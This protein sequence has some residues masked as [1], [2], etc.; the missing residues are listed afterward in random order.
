MAGTFS[1][2]CDGL[3][4][5]HVVGRTVRPTIL[6]EP[7]TS[8]DAPLSAGKHL[9]VRYSLEGTVNSESVRAVSRRLIFFTLTTDDGTAHECLAKGR[10]RCLTDSEIELLASRL[11]G[12]VDRSIRVRITGFPEVS[13]V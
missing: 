11:A 5:G 2:S 12:A 1:K 4:D 13:E 9:T 7:A 3:S 6:M 8:S 10:D